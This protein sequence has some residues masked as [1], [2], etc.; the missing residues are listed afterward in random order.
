MGIAV[1]GGEEHV[2]VRDHLGGDRLGAAHG[3]DLG[4]R[5]LERYDDAAELIEIGGDRE[6][7][8]FRQD[9]PAFGA[10]ARA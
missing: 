2:A 3:I 6:H 1:A 7:T 8:S 9:S 4:A 10:K 5:A